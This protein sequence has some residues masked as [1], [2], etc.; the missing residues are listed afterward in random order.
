MNAYL[1]YRY[2]IDLQPSSGYFKMLLPF[3]IFF[4]VLFIVSTYFQFFFHAGKKW[5]YHKFQLAEK[6]SSWLY[7]TSV[8]GFFYLF[9]RYEGIKFLSA[10]ILLVLLL[11]M[12]VYWGYTVYLF[13][14]QKYLPSLQHKSQNAQ[15]RSYMP[16]K[17]KK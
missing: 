3:L 4:C 6:I 13:Y 10:R 7:T 16:K 2:Y 11:I 9:F 12:F 1:D 15:Q 17:R 5:D 14:Q 8:L